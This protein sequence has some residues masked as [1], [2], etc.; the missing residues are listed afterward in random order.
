MKLFQINTT[1]N[2]GSTGRIA[3]QIGNI[4]FRQGYDSYIAYGRNL[5]KSDN[6]IIRIGN[7]VDWKRHVLCSR[8]FDNHGFSSIQATKQFLKQLE[9]LKPDIIH[10][11]NIHGY[12]LNIE[13][14]FNYLSKAQI[15]VVWT[16]HDCWPMTGHCAHFDF[17]KCYKWQT[18][19]EYCPNKR[20]YPASFFH[21]RSK[22]NYY[23]KK[24]LFTSIERM[25]FVAPSQW[26]ADIV[27]QSFLKDYPV[28]IIHNGIDL[29]VFKPQTKTGICAKYNIGD[30]PFILGVA[31]VWGQRKGLDDFIL[32]SR[33]LPHNLQIVLVG[34][35]D[36]Q[37]RK[38]PH[39][40]IGVNRTT[41]VHELAALY[42]ETEVFVNPTWVDNFPTTNIEAL[43]CGTPV[44]TYRT[45][46]SPEAI[47]RDTG[48]VVEKGDI[49]GVYQ[50]IL[51]V[52]KREKKQYIQ[53]CRL[54]AEQKF[55]KEQIFQQY[56]RLYE[57]LLS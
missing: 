56:I 16:L 51:T 1:V 40:I 2:V 49:N 7:S 43:A 8:L 24:E 26:L 50:A 11:H 32:L 48:F 19:C 27:E 52:I 6:K 31:N 14:L 22:Y 28:R 39:N 30:R 36:S 38:L 29:S 20:K 35:N 53:P 13:L 41:N 12:Y 10:L 5:N 9:Q 4:A 15:P 42:A 37:K 44:I 55:D 54:Q 21:D 33:L 25:V 34:L 17:V 23:R 47:S 46:G 45:G 3:E 18:G 57:Q